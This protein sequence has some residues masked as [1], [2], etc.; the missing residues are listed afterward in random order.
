MS[1]QTLKQALTAR[2]SKKKSSKK[3][4][5]SST[6]SALHRA[7]RQALLDAG[8][9]VGLAVIGDGI[10]I[11]DRNIIADD[12]ALLSQALNQGEAKMSLNDL[13]LAVICYQIADLK[14]D[15]DRK[16]IREAC[17][18]VVDSLNKAYADGSHPWLK[19]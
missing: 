17:Q 11:M 4:G 15:D 2:A 14:S 18:R 7:D 13:R 12:S 16:I 19:A 8:K 5:I 10:S 9:P 6:N 3:S 1:D